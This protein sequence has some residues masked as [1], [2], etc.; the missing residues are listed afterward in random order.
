MELSL[1][2]SYEEAREL[3]NS[4]EEQCASAPGCS[5]TACKAWDGRA[6]PSLPRSVSSVSVPLVMGFAP[7]GIAGAVMGVSPPMA[8][9]RRLPASS[10][11]SR[12]LAC[13]SP[14]LL[15]ELEAN[16]AMLAC[17]T[18]FRQRPAPCSPDPSTSRRCSSDRAAG[19]AAHDTPSKK[20][21]ARRP[22]GT[23]STPSKPRHGAGLPRFWK[24]DLSARLIYDCSRDDEEVCSIIEVATG[25]PMEVE[26]DDNHIE[27]SKAKRRRCSVEDAKDLSG[28]LDVR[29]AY[30]EVKDTIGMSF[31]EFMEIYYSG[32]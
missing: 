21:R 5:S 17:Q 22:T 9:R 28:T 2:F 11:P 12:D 24:T 13:I 14:G 26:D 10:V 6:P 25:V 1:D 7:G 3:L 32:F 15:A 27:L 23:F 29:A 18:P 8:G 31:D 4:L 16:H 20:A 19:P 30:D